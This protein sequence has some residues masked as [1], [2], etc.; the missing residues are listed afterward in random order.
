MNTTIIQLEEIDD[1][2]SIK[3]KLMHS[4]S[5]RVLMVWP[6]SGFIPLSSIDCLLILRYAESLG[7]QIG[8]VLDDPSILRIMKNA[9]IS[10]FSSIPEAQ[11]KPW[12]KPTIKKNNFIS[13]KGETKP[14]FQSY[15]A[16]KNSIPKNLPLVIRWLLFLL[17]IISF[18]ILVIF[19][20]PSATVTISPQREIQELTLP[21][22]SEL[23]IQQVSLA[24]SVPLTSTTVEIEGEIEG[25]SSGTIRLPDKFAI[26]EVVFRNLSDRPITIPEG[27]IIRTDGDP[28]VRYKTQKELFL[29]GGIQSEIIAP[30]VS[31]VAGIEGNVG[32]NSITIVEGD[33]GGNVAVTNPEPTTG[34]GDIKTFSPTERDY[35]KAKEELIHL[36]SKK[37]YQELIENQVLE[38]YIPKE[39]VK[40]KE[41]KESEMSPE[42]GNPAERFTIKLKLTFSASMVSKDD[43][44]NYSNMALNSDLNKNNLPVKGTI[45]YAINE[46]SIILNEEMIEFEIRSSQVII[47]KFDNQ[48]IIQKIIG[49]QK[50]QAVLIIKKEIKVDNEPQISIVPSF[51]NHLPFLPFRIN[52]VIDE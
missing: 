46:D 29:P 14:F 9:G 31:L 16:T 19:L 36:L 20:I 44:M 25:V 13:R 1:I 43:I 17:G 24:G 52:L 47:P 40:F 8:M 30:V 35:E 48:Q 15:L 2:P 41:I 26:G 33:F 34:G 28:I 38:Y 22:K 49:L 42:I 50:E 51:W 27:T 18:V 32:S 11:K 45:E 10:T 39:S 6:N 23:T 21:I 7:I 3:N 5:Q 12:R 4:K 37:A